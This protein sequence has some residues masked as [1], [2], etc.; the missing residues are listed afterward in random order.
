MGMATD[1][2]GQSRFANA[3]SCMYPMIGKAA[4]LRNTYAWRETTLHTDRSLQSKPMSVDLTCVRVRGRST[5]T[6]RTPVQGLHRLH[7]NLNRFVSGKGRNNTLLKPPVT[8]YFQL[9]GV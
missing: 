2:N 7:N 5:E 4:D 9:R 8:N 3:E 6:I 1:D